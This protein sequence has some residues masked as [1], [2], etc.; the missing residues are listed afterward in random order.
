M[1]IAFYD[2]KAYD[3][4][5]FDSLN[6]TY[7]FKIKYFESKLNEDTAKL[8]K[9]YDAVCAFV[10][11]TINKEVVDILNELGVGLV[12]MRCAG[13]NNVDFEAAKDKLKVVRV[14]AYS[15]YAVAEHALALIMTLN[16][17]T[18]KA[19]SRTRDNNF[20]IAGLQGFDLYGKTVGV[21]GTGEN[22]S[23]FCR[24]MWWYRYES[25]GL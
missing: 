13:Y 8:A 12:A 25:F 3:I 23:Y 20:N 18:H 7:G 14:P 22:R 11:D 6:K 1:K 10:N 24:Y 16:R 17:K 4:K 9:G 19:Y 5:S 2:A 21:I 15:P